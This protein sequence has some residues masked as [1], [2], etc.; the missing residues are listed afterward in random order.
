MTDLEQL[1]RETVQSLSL[2][3]E[4]DLEAHILA[5]LRQAVD[6]FNRDIDYWHDLYKEEQQ[7]VI[8]RDELLR[9]AEQLFVHAKEFVQDWRKGDFEL[10]RL[11]SCDAA[12]LEE[13]CI[14]Y[15]AAMARYEALMKEGK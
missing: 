12:S 14:K 15:A 8:T 2:I 13:A 3:R 6:K 1:A 5:T 4:C 9:E 11:A 10:S 7:K